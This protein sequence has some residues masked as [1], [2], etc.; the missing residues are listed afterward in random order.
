MTPNFLW[1]LLWDFPG[2]VR[3]STSVIRA[4]LSNQTSPG[5]PCHPSIFWECS[6]MHCLHAVCT[7]IY[8]FRPFDLICHQFACP[9]GPNDCPC[10]GH[11]S[12]TSRCK[13]I[14]FPGCNG[15]KTSR[16]SSGRTGHARGAKHPLFVQVRAKLEVSV[17][18]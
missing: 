12:S 2:S 18:R 17:F 15:Q 4:F 16:F 9:R 8:V 3:S 1:L 14:E 6:G 11:H 10:T 13:K 7:D 5:H